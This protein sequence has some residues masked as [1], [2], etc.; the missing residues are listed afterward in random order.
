MQLSSFVS[1]VVALC[2]L[3][4]SLARVSHITT[5]A[6]VDADKPFKVTLHTEKM[7]GWSDYSVIFG[8]KVTPLPPCDTC[9]GTPVSSA[10]L[11]TKHWQT[12]DGSF[13]EYIAAPSHAGTYNLTAVITSVYTNGIYGPETGIRYYSTKVQVGKQSPHVV[14]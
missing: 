10:F 14:Y 9:I 7:D 11:R 13:P 1:V 4:S 2:M 3:S 12:G 5:P 6:Q 8:M